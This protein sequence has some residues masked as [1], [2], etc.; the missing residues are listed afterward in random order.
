VCS[1]D[2]P[3]VTPKNIVVELPNAVDVRTFAIDPAPGCGLPG[4]AST[5]EYRVETSSAQSLPAPADPSWR[6]AAQGAFVAADRPRLNTVTPAPGSGTA[7]RFVRF[8]MLSPQVPGVFG[9]TCATSGAAG[10]QFMGVSE[11]GT[12]GTAAP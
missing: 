1:S 12:Y 2:L 8:T 6:L 11:L 7:V 3:V 5:K 10:C 4:D 9:A